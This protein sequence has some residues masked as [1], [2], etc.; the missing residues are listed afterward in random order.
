LPRYSP[1]WN[2][3][4]FTTFWNMLKFVCANISIVHGER[5]HI[6]STNVQCRSHGSNSI[7]RW[8]WPELRSGVIETR[9]Y[10]HFSI[11][12]LCSQFKMLYDVCLT[13]CV[14]V[15]VRLLSIT[16][17]I[18][19]FFWTSFRLLI[20]PLHA[21]TDLDVIPIRMLFHVF[22]WLFFRSGKYW[23]NWIKSR[24]P[25]N[26]GSGEITLTCSD[27]RAR[28][29]D[30]KRSPWSMFERRQNVSKIVKFTYLI[31][32]FSVVHNS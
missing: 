30:G 21:R 24:R 22:K 29:A 20:F 17:Q 25:I 28:S 31:V 3:A 4:H 10:Q 5:N 13:G 26:L 11:F 6:W 15:F 14:S 19:V 7:V 32:S 27:W 9:S 1:A 12:S 16:R 18:N 8:Q 23:R 2:L